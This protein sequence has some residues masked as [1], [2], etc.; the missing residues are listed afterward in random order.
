MEVGEIG[1]SWPSPAV[2]PKGEVTKLEGEQLPE[3]ASSS[4]PT[5]LFLEGLGV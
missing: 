5:R 2:E 3:A 1:D 4:S